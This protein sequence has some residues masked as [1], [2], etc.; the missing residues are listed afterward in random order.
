[1]DFEWRRKNYFVIFPILYTIKY[2][3]IHILRDRHVQQATAVQ[4]II[5]HVR[6]NSV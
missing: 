6:C 1:M 2:L 5:T 4:Q 3:S